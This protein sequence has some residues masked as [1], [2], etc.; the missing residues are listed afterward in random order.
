MEA[1]ENGGAGHD[2]P[3]KTV[4]PASSPQEPT[5]RL[6]IDLP[7]TMH[8]RFKTACSATRRKMTKEIEAFILR[9]T[10]ELEEESGINHKCTYPHL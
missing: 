7:Q 4:K 1:F 10:S 5:R 6:S 3:R 8:L 9:R 2:T